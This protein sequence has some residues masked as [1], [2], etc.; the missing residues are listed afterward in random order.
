MRLRL[1]LL[2]GGRSLGRR[3]ARPA[4]GPHRDRHARPHARPPAPGQPV[5]QAACA[6]SC[7]TKATR[8]S[9]AASRPTSS[10]S[11]PTRRRQRQTALFSATLP[12]WVAGTASKHLHAPVTVAV[13]AGETSAPEIEHV[14]YD[15]DPA[16]KLGALMTLLDRRGDQPGHRLRAHQARR[17]EAGPAAGRAGLSRRRRCRAT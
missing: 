9:T 2:Y 14:V 12:D 16:A 4:G 10:A 13:D 17:Q 7:S 15:V 11:W 1:T 3:E 6:S 5:A 8:C